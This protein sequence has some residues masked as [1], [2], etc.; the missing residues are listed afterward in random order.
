MAQ[1][2]VRVGAIPTVDDL[3]V[4]VSGSVDNEL[5]VLANDILDDNEA[6]EYA[7]AGV[8]GA[9]SNG[10]VSVTASNTV[11]YSPDSAHAG[12]YPYTERFVYTIEDDA[13]I[14]VTTEVR[15]LVVDKDSDRD[16]ATIY[17]AGGGARRGVHERLSAGGGRCRSR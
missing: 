9:T 4:V 2:K 11:L 17:V 13:G 16:T 15:V 5:D 7:L 3:F 12:P 10:T 6:S 14:A 8:S 1:V